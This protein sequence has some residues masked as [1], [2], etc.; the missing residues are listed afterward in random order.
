MYV[1]PGP[2][3]Y[4]HIEV[5]VLKL[6]DGPSLTTCRVLVADSGVENVND[7]VDVTLAPRSAGATW[8]KS[9]WPDRIRSWRP[10]GARACIRG[11]ISTRLPVEVPDAH[12]PRLDRVA[13]FDRGHAPTHLCDPAPV[14]RESFVIACHD[15]VPMDS[16]I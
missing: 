8:R 11:S 16:E 12:V 10:G 5:T 9:S 1:H 3:E 15:P 2:N 13:Q 14:R 7:A 4:W 6:L